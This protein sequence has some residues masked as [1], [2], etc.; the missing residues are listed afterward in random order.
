MPTWEKLI[1]YTDLSKA[2]PRTSKIWHPLSEYSLVPKWSLSRVT[3]RSK[4]KFGTQVSF[5]LLS[6]TVTVSSYHFSV[7][8][9]KYR[10]Y[11]KAQGA[12]VVYDITKENTFKNVKRWIEGI[13][14]HAS[15]NVVIYIIGNKSDLRAIQ[16]VG[17]AEGKT[18]AK[19]M[20]CFF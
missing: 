11:R 13:R 1:L 5:I 7:S 19:E 12:L 6:W 15:E 9:E 2:V 8:V 20:G 4:F 17:T 14:E 3:K 18:L 16:T 10:H